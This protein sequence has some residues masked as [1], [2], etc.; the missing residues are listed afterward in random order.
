[1]E[2]K[3]NNYAEIIMSEEPEEN[4]VQE[5]EDIPKTSETEQEVEQ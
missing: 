5:V 4:N 2:E 1:M 3:L